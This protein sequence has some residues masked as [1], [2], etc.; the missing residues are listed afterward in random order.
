M[1]KYCGKNDILKIGLTGGIGSGKSLVSKVFST[2]GIPVYDA[3]SNA[4]RIM[5][6]SKEI[7]NKLI[8]CFGENSFIKDKLNR[9]YLADIVFNNPEELQKLN[10]IIHPAVTVD[11]I[12]WSKQQ[13]P[14]PYVI[15]EAAILYESGW[16]KVM[17]KTILVEAPDEIRIE[18]TMQRDNTSR[19]EVL[20]RI[21]NQWPTAKIKPLT[22]FII[23][24]D[25]KQLVLSQVIDIDKRLKA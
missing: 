24:N 6:T 19:E 10:N 8:D 9:K 16:Y 2:L 13:N 12:E 15:Y 11:F 23:Q 4:K 21:K 14:A 20:K 25:N 5:N 17:D 22:D 1:L 7:K 3:D 18:R